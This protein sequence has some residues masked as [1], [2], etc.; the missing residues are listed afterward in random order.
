MNRA[1]GRMTGSALVLVVMTAALTAGCGDDS[2]SPQPPST[3]DAGVIAA[4]CAAGERARA[5]DRGGARTIFFDLAHD[6]VHQLAADVGDDD[7]ATQARLLEAE[8]RVETALAASSTPELVAALDALAQA[9]ADA[10]EAN[11]DPRPES[12]RP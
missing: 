4:L 9:A 2:G 10:L 11:G 1:V 8:Q 12:C 7:R 6:A 5:D 3:P